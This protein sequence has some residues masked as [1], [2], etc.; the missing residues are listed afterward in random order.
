MTTNI[1]SSIAW[2]NWFWQL[3]GVVLLLL[4]FGAGLGTVVTGR[5]LNAEQSAEIRQQ[6]GRIAELNEQAAQLSK[7]A[8]EARLKQLQL[9]SIV[10]WRTLS[11]EQLDAL[12]AELSANPSSVEIIVVGNDPEALFFAIQLS[13]AFK[14]WQ[15]ATG[16]SDMMGVLEIGLSI[17]GID[18]VAVRNV[19]SAFTAAKLGFADQRPRPP[20]ATMGFGSRSG[21]KEPSKVTL[22]VGSKFR[23]EMETFRP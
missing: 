22:S 18:E 16:N 17:S 19:R 13:K 8:E 15:V 7:E 6:R 20:G 12:T 2:W 5:W 9:Q 3:A 11:K 4:T 23:P 10:E 21:P 1:L 14:G